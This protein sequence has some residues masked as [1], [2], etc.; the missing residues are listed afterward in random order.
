MKAAAFIAV[1]AALVAVGY[2]HERQFREEQASAQRAFVAWAED[3]CIPRSAGQRGVAERR[4]DGA[5][6]CAIY[7]NA[8]HGSAP[9]LV[10]A[11]VRE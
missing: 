11:E 7:E 3:N 4:R 1:A 9:R 2:V 8:G 6:Q 5:V 10:Y